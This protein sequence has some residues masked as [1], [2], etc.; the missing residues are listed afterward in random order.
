MR[1]RL[2]LVAL[3][4]GCGGK[5]VN[6]GGPTQDD[7]IDDRDAGTGG[8]DGG[9][10]GGTGGDGGADAGL[11]GYAAR[12]TRSPRPTDEVPGGDA[13][14]DALICCTSTTDINCQVPRPD[15]G[16]SPARRIVIAEPGSARITVQIYSD[17][18]CRTL[19]R[20]LS[21]VLPFE[22]GPDLWAVEVDFTPPLPAG[23]QLSMKWT[24]GAGP[25]GCPQTECQPYTVGS[26]PEGCWDYL[27]QH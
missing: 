3:L 27:R 19:D 15:A 25:L 12:L 5:H 8:P 14:G 2:L 20:T 7:S 6:G 22:Y 18:Q 17:T 23:F 4:F 24:T 21:A 26:A 9:N 10:D 11:A 1:Y 16:F 13:P